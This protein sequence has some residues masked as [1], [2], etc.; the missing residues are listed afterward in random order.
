MK[1]KLGP[2]HRATLAGMNNLARAYWGLKRLDRSISLFEEALKRQEKQLGRHHPDTL[3]VMAN[4]GV[5]YR[6]AGRLVDAIALLEESYA[7]GKT[8]GSLRWVGTELLDTYVRADK[9]AEA[10]KLIRQ[11]LADVRQQLPR[12]SPQ[13]A[14]EL[15]RFGWVLLQV[16]AFP[17]AEPM[18]RECLAIRGK[19][20]QDSWLTFNTQSILGGALLGQK[21]Y[22]AAEPLLLKGYEGMKARA[23]TIPQMGGGEYRIPEALDRLIELYT[24]LNKP[25][26]AKKWQAERA[27][28]PAATKPEAKK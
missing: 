4:L 15:A 7:A 11:R 3:L 18:L 23:Q 21:K 27:K 19:Q 22:A 13:L 20:M 12:D 28:Y 1:A 10:S 26:E 17:D 8:H 9:R 6:D 5:D 24:A 25:D 16:K 14:G 2:D